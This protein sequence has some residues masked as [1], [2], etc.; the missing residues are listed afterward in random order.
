MGGKLR[1]F[2]LLAETR[3]LEGDCKYH[4]DLVKHH[5]NRL[6]SNLRR[7]GPSLESRVKLWGDNI[8]KL[9]SSETNDGPVV[10]FI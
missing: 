10:D 3:G 2:E 9:Y 1:E 4:Y 5:T 6:E 8:K 7:K